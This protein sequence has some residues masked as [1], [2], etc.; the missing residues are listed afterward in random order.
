MSTI[1]DFIKLKSGYANFVELKS[2]YEE[3]QEN[4]DRME[5]YRPTKSHR[6]AFERICR[7]IYQ[8]NDK[9]FYLLS[10]SYGTGKSHLCLM[11]ANFLSRSSGDP[12]MKGFYENYTQLDPEQGKLL[13][14]IRKD[15][16]YLVAICDYHS[17]RRFE[18]V[19]LK[20]VLEASNSRG[21]NTAINTEFDEAENLLK[22]WFEEGGKGNIRNFYEDFIKALA[23]VAPSLSIKQLRARLVDCDSNAL[24]DF[25]AAFREMM[26][27]LEFQPQSGNL[28]QILKSFLKSAEFKERFKGLAIFFDEFGFTLEKSAYSK[29]VLQGFMESICQNEPNVLFVGCIHQNFKAYADRFSTEDASVMNARITHVDLFNEGVEEIISAIVETDK[30]SSIWKNSIEP[31]TS[32]FDHLVPLCKSLNLFPWIDDVNRIRQRVLEDIYGMH[33]MAL[34]CLLR[35]SLEIGS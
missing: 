16:Q 18:D 30:Q 32:I 20:A 6:Q 33:P 34:A 35:L 15:G 31:K 10:G 19:V 29:D 2:A 13:K 1:G 11:T 27:G 25:R 4:A 12:E 5:M 22:V 7:G 21:L 17:G 8:P 26:G 14:N 3:T 28:I 23:Q 24:S 9:K